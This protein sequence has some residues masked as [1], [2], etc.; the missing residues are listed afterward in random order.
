MLGKC[1]RG[2]GTAIVSQEGLRYHTMFTTNCL[3]QL[4]G[5]E[6][7]MTVEVCLEFD[8]DEFRSMVNEQTSTRIHVIGIRFAPGGEQAALCRTDK[9][10][11]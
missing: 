2:E 10:V 9:V 6:G 1:L 4:L 7:L 8:M 5:L 3:K 11:N